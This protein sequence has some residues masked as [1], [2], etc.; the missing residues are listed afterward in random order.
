MMPGMI[1]FVSVRKDDGSRELVQKKLILCNLSELYENFKAQHPAV[2]ISLSKFSQLRPRNCILAGAS[3]THT[4]CVCVYHENVNLMLDAVDLKEPSCEN[5]YPI[6][7]YHDAMNS[8]MCSVP[9]SECSLNKCTACPGTSALKNF[10][11]SILTDQCIKGVHL[12]KIFEK[13]IFFLTF[14]ASLRYD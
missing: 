12:C 5:F 1:D 11:T 8:I 14:F 9:T 7:N 10:I 2:E 4:V 3:G 13:S 6:M